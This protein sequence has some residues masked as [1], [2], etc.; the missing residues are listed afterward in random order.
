MAAVVAGSLEPIERLASRLDLSSDDLTLYG[1]YRAKIRIDPSPPPQVRQG[2]YVL[3]TG[4]TP[5]HHNAGKTVTTI[6][7]AMGLERIGHRATV[8]LRQS[9]FG[10]TFGAKGGGGGG[11]KARIEPLEESLIGLGADVFAVEMAN[12]LLAAVVDDAVHRGRLVDPASVTWRRV[13]DVDDRALRQIRAGLGGTL[14]G[15]EHQTGF[16]ITAASEVMAILTLSRDLAD[17]RSR[18]SSIVPAWDADGKPVTAG[19]LETAGSMAVLLRD[20]IRPNLMQTSDRTPAM[21]HTGPFGNIA[22]GN[23]SVIADIVSLAPE[24]FCGDRGGIRFR[25]RRREVL[26]PQVPLSRG[27]R[28]T[29]QC[30]WPRSPASAITEVQMVTGQML[31]PLQPGAD[32][33][34]SPRRKPPRIRRSRPSSPSTGFPATATTRWPLSLLLPVTQVPPRWQSTKRLLWEVPGCIELAEA[35]ASCRRERRS[36]GRRSSSVVRPPRAG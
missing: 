7:L 3:V 22:P 21:V 25:S 33:L 18:L 30:S 19:S 20:A 12:N 13:L 5:T 14:N 29:S 2:R 31:P 35:V 36:P 26:P 28:R 1:R 11:G 17:L 8:T 10:P 16:D 23:S 4:I 27:W 34:A 9:S 32:N 24:R 15:P 6:G